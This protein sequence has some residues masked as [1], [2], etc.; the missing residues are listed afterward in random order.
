M[1]KHKQ[2]SEGIELNHLES[3]NG[4]RNNKEITKRD[5]P[6]N[7]K[8]RKDIRSHRCKHQQK[9]TRDRRENIRDRRYHKKH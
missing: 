2:A 5:N 7:R 3:K 8:P 6:R 4:N 9:N 1:G